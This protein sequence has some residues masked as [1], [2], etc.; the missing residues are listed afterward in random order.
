MA[1][2][3]TLVGLDVS[4]LSHRGFGRNPGFAGFLIASISAEFVENQLSQS[5]TT[6]SPRRSGE[7]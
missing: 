2:G 1:K 5:T 6:R 7:S 3:M 4:G